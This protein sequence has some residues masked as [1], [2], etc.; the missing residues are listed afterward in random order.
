MATQSTWGLISRVS[1]RTYGSF[2]TVVTNMEQIGD[3][4]SFQKQATIKVVQ[5]KLN[6]T[7][8]KRYVKNVGLGIK[9]PKD[10]RSMSYVDKECPFTGNVAIRGRLLSGVVTKLK[11]QRSCTVRRDYLHYIKKYQRFEKRHKMVSA[12]V[13]PCWQISPLAIWSPS[14]NADHCP[15]PSTS[16]LSKSTKSEPPR[17]DSV[18]FK[19][20]FVQKF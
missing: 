7:V 19:F 2:T 5:N 10:A 3:S 12:H 13:S 4:R 20:L 6:K 15:R 18:N 16:T 8:Q 1:S 9:T 11:M 17:K 14:V